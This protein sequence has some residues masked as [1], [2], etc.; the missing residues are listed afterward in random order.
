MTTLENRD[1]TLYKDTS[2]YVYDPRRHNVVNMGTVGNPLTGS[3]YGMIGKRYP[4]HAC[5]L[6]FGRINCTGYII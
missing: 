6:P 1:V 2:T 3:A 4:R 5:D